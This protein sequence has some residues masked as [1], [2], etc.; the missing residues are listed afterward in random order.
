MHYSLANSRTSEKIERF[1]VIH[2]AY[3]CHEKWI[4]SGC[5][6]SL[7]HQYETTSIYHHTCLH[8]TKYLLAPKN[9]LNLLLNFGKPELTLFVTYVTQTE[10]GV[11][12]GF[13]LSQCQG[14]MT[15]PKTHIHIRTHTYRNTNT[16][17][18]SL[19]PKIPIV[20]MFCHSPA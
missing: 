2:C 13:C 18:P 14:E 3:C 1:S 6:N 7:P 12:G 9:V 10:K 5:I 11:I 4:Y 20:T 16:H 15:S 8:Q 17:T 19:I